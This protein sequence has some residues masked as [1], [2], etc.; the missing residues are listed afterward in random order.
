MVKHNCVKATGTN[1]TIDHLPKSTN[2]GDD[3]RALIIDLIG[4]LRF[5]AFSNAV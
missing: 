5:N 3:H 2:A 1:Q 4:L